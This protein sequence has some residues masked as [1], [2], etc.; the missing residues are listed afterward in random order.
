MVVVK[1]DYVITGMDIG[2]AEMQVVELL[3]ELKNRGHSVR[4]ISLTTPVALIQRLQRQNIPVI[5]L[6][7]QGFISSLYGVLKLIYLIKKHKPDVL[8]S[9][10]F[11]ANII[12]RFVTIFI[13]ATPLICTVHSTNEG[14]KIRDWIYRLTNRLC[15]L[16]T[17]VSDAAKR[18]FINDHVFSKKHTI[19]VFNGINTEKFLIARNKKKDKFRWLTVGRLVS[20]KNQ[21]AIVQAMH[22]LPKSELTI[23]GD[24]PEKDTLR[25]YI[26]D[27]GLEKRVC[28]VGSSLDV[29]KY[30]NMADGFVLASKYEGFAL[31]VAEAMASGLM[32]V[33]TECGGPSEILG[34]DNGIIVPQGNV[35]DLSSAMAEVEKISYED[36]YALGIQ[37]RARVESLFSIKKIV[38][39]WEAIYCHA[40]K[41]TT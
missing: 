26:I 19:S 4:L 2:G 27:N 20:V 16:N 36:R 40:V 23:V 30:Y 35:D 22:K 21:I 8:H 12:S 39:E 11:H 7:M 17:A 33:T 24:G 32:V 37:G 1:I 15:Y 25:K 31:V 38:S 3:L 14:G 10:M 13:A 34:K 18:R 9:H 5:S 6:D 41:K 28:L 29:A